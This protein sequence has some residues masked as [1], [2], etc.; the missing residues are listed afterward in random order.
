VLVFSVP[1]K[2]LRNFTQRLL[3]HNVGL[4][5]FYVHLLLLYTMAASCGLFSFTDPSSPVEALNKQMSQAG[6][7]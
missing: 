2:A 6:V 4:W 1:D 3:K 7:G 5:I